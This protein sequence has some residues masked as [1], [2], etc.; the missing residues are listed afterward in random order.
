MLVDLARND[1]GRVCEIGSVKVAALRVGREVLARAAPRLRGPRAARGRAQRRGRAGRVLPGRHADR[2]AEDPRDGADR[3]ARGRAARRLRRRGRVPRRRRQLRRRDR[4]PHGRRREGRLAR[5]RPAPGSSPTPSPRRSTRRPSPRRRRSSAPS[6]SPASGVVRPQVPVMIF[7]VDN[8]D[9]FTYN[10][11]QALGKLDPDVEVARNDRFDPEAMLAARPR[12]DRDLARAR[13]AGECRPLDRDDRRGRA[14]RRSRCSA[15]ASATRR[16]RAFHGGVVERAPAP[17]H[18]KSSPVR[19]RRVRALRRARRTRSR[20][21]GTI[22][23]WSAKTACRPSL[24]SRRAATTA[25]SWP[26]RT[27]RSPSSACSSIPSPC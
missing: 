3:R 22:R 18:G 11:V 6:S 1:L 12:G 27:G 2:R 4:D 5:S 13:P 20:P 10:L 14:R 7:V 16:S 15:S 24:P 26:W 25:S 9:S 19:A 8:Y 21:G 17:R 23:S